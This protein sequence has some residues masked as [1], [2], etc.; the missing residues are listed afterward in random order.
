MQH[1]Y[2]E[3][4]ICPEKKELCQLSVHQRVDVLHAFFSK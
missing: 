4:S 1:K 3:S 2:A